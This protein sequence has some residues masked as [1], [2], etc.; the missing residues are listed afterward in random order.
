MG[1]YSKK[2]DTTELSS[3]VIGKVKSKRA[4][5]IPLFLVIAIFM[6]SIYFVDDILAYASKYLGINLVDKDPSSTPVL[7]VDKKNYIE[8]AYTPSMSIV[9]PDFPFTVSNLVAD[10]G[11]ISYTIENTSKEEIKIAGDKSYYFIEF[12]AVIK[13]ED[14]TT[15]KQ[16]LVRTIL[17]DDTI[18]A[19]EK[20]DYSNDFS[21]LKVDYSRIN[22][23]VLANV[24]PIDYVPSKDDIIV[25]KSVIFDDQLTMACVRKNETLYY[26][27]KADD[28]TLLGITDEIKVPIEEY[29]EDDF[30]D[31]IG[32]VDGY[33]ME[34]A[35]DGAYKQVNIMVDLSRAKVKLDDKYYS[36]GAYPN[37]IS[38]EMEA[39]GYS[40]E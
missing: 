27:F 9:N 21:A 38:F 26:N 24:K 4:T 40:C 23:V 37:V 20:K 29:K 31:Y 15:N 1:K 11:M 25:K 7:P 8:L 19:G 3:T 12:Y 34:V 14:G 39:R 6:S 32:N 30:S 22:N 33:S 35:D 18:A 36:N 2:I 5:L 13:N 17:K 10:E 28:K 16:F